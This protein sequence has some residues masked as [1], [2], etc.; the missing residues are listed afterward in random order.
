M[1]PG[2]AGDTSQPPQTSA[3]QG[4]RFG[5]GG[6]RT[7]AQVATVSLAEVISPDVVI[8]LRVRCTESLSPHDIVGHNDSSVEVE[9]A[10]Q[11]YFCH[12]MDRDRRQV[13]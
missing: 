13:C 1:R 12:Q 7:G 8:S 2:V 11:V 9:V 5:H 4:R 3:A 10:R 6:I